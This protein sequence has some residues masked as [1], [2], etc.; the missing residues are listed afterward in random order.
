MKIDRKTT[1]FM[2]LAVLCFSIGLVNAYGQSDFNQ[3]ALEYFKRSL[4]FM[5][6]GDYDSAILNCNV[7]LRL[8]S[9]S[10]AT[11]AIRA[12]AHY[13]KGDMDSAIA[14]STQAL[15]L[16]RN[17]ISA[18]IIRGNAYAR[19]GN[20]DSAIADWQAVLRVDPEN[21]DARTNIDL[22]RERRES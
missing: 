22:I 13:E 2:L 1:L 16:D 7:V 20:I 3:R 19:N 17:N 21:T 6:I 5:I 12:R 11:Y 4:Q 9:N 10:A 15:R 14:D 8:D 18:H